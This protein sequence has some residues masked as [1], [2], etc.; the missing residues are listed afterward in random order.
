[1]NNDISVYCYINIGVD[2]LNELTQRILAVSDT[3]DIRDTY[4]TENDALQGVADCIIN[5]PLT[6]IS[7]LLTIIEDLQ[8]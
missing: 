4:D 7:E 5:D 3:Y 2:E 8:N 1:M 6:V